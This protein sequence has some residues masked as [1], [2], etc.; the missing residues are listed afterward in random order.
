MAVDSFG[1]VSCFLGW[2]RI[3]K[4]GMA[5]RGDPVSRSR[6]ILELQVLQ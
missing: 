4:T 6:F 5:P 2:E 1:H 3:V